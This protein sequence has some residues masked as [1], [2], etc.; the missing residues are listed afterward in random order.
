MKSPTTRTQTTTAAVYPDSGDPR[1]DVRRLAP[2]ILR[3]EAGEVCLGLHY[4]ARW[5]DGYGARG[6]KLA[7]SLADPEII[8]STRETGA[9]LPTSV[10][11]HDALDHLISGFAPSGHRAEAMALAQLAR[12]TGSDP[13]PDY[14]QMIRE[15]LLHGQ[16]VG[17]RAWTFI[18]AALRRQC[19]PEIALHDD[20]AV[21]A[22]LRRRLGDAALTEALLARFQA[23][24]EAGHAHAVASWRRLGLEP[25]RRGPLGLAMQAVLEP[26]DRLAEAR[27]WP[28][29][30]G[31]L[32]LSARG[33]AFVSSG[34][35]LSARADADRIC[36][37]GAAR[38]TKSL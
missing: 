28:A 33:C 11:V 13:K 25:E 23:L 27:Q 14:C 9:T 5:D 16:I 30:C 4:R 19:T 22:D 29:W 6:W 35:P 37:D 38:P 24:G 15:D 8:A 21:M 31:E 2:E 18:G 26:I 17:E 10:L 1:R 36:K 34:P 20:R 7:V 3:V 32:R 12:R